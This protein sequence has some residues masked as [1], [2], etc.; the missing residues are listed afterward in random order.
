MR[1]ETAPFV[2]TTK[3]MSS[4]IAAPE[5]AC[6]VTVRSTSP[7]G[8]T[9]ASG[10]TEIVVPV[11]AVCGCRVTDHVPAPL[12]ASVICRIVPRETAPLVTFNSPSD[13][14]DGSVKICG[15]FARATLIRP[16]PSSV[17]A[18]SAVRSVLPH[19]GPEVDISA[20]LT[21]CVD[22]VGCCW[23]SSAAAPA[24]CGAAMLV[25]SKTANGEPWNSVSVEDRICPPGAARS[26]FSR[27][28]NAVGPAPEKLVTM[29]LR[30][31]AMSSVPWPIRIWMR[32]AE[33]IA[34]RR[35]APSTSA[36]IPDG[37][38]SWIGSGFASPKRLSTR[39]MPIAPAAR[40]RPAL[41]ANEHVPRETSAIAP[42]S[43]LAGSGLSAPLG[44]A[45]LPQR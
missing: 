15:S 17:T 37:I 30:P 6:A 28:P 40:A 25:P 34:A 22:H 31:V 38:C 26:G 32:P 12:P 7:P 23:T 10:G 2:S 4:P 45:V 33:P 21:C 39:T 11:D 36:I 29:P 3:P 41:D 24:T 20:D 43:E 9:A 19:A 13:T 8:A 27:W 44:S 18:A 42:V 5:D 16:A 14:D 1:R 35:A